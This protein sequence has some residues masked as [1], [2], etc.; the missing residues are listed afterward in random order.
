MTDLHQWNST[1]PARTK[2]IE[3]SGKPKKSNP[4]RSGKNRLRAYGPPAKRAWIRSLP[5]AH[6]GVVGFSV[7]AHTR[8]GGKGWKANHRHVAP[9]CMPRQ[10]A[11]GNWYDGCHK[12]H[13]EHRAP[14][15]Q[16]DVREA[17]KAAAARIYD[18]W[19]E[20]EAYITEE[21]SNA[22]SADD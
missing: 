9:L 16:P 3:R 14:F 15:D 2:P 12:L 22:G 6:C 10:L 13:D 8:A 18:E 5:C 19:C 4:T 1:L 7:N 11:D 17:V 20:M 21:F